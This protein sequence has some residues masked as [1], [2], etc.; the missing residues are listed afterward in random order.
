MYYV[1]IGPGTSD[2]HDCERSHKSKFGDRKF[3]RPSDDIV[4]IVWYWS[5]CY[6]WQGDRRMY[7]QSTV[8]TS[9]KF[10][11]RWPVLKLFVYFVVTFLRPPLT[12]NEHRMIQTPEYTQVT[13]SNSPGRE[14]TGPLLV[15]SLSTVH[16]LISRTQIINCLSVIQRKPRYH[17]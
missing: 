7:F 13:M 11:K 5:T 2:P 10:V 16:S 1:Y 3:H 12:H 9:V 17:F 15:F 8:G 6:P 14:R 4:G